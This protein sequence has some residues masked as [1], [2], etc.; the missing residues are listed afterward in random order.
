[1]NVLVVGAGEMGRWFGAVLQDDP[2]LAVDLAVTDADPAIAEAAADAIAA[3]AVPLET[4]ERFDLVC[5]AVPIPATRDVIAEF[6]DNATAAVADLAGYM[7]GPLA[8]MAEH[9]PERERISLHPLFAAANAPGNVAAVVENGGE[10]ATA[11]RSALSS[12]GNRWVETDAPTHDEAMETVQASAHAAVLAFALAAREV[13]E[14][15]HTPIS[16]GLFDL[17]EQVTG[18]DPRVYADIQETF[19]GAGAV[20]DAAGRLADADRAEFV[21]LYRE[22]SDE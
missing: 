2:D 5:V 21:E 11:V 22:A 16:A 12:R 3:R 14:A 18:N 6:A 9:A 13:P 15:F 1:M 10:I 8:A 20:A 17:V 7:A 19:E 4:D